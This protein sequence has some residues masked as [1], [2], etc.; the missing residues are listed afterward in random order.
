[1]KPNTPF[2]KDP[3]ALAAFMVMV[4]VALGKIPFPDFFSDFDEL[5]KSEEC[6]CMKDELDLEKPFEG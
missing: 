4:D 2:T 1:M 6:Q 3:R 5:L